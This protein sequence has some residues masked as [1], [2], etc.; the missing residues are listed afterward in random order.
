LIAAGRDRADIAADRAKW[1]E[2]MKD[3]DADKL[4]F[5]DES[6][7][8][9]KMTRLCGR[10]ARGAPCIGAVPDGHW[11]NNTF[12][13]GLRAARIDAPMLLTG[14]MNGAA[15]AAWVEQSL[16]PTLKPGDIVICDNLNVHKNASARRAIE[17]RGAALRFLPAY[18]PDLNPIEMLFA[19]LKN[20][21]RSAEARCFNPDN[22]ASG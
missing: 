13:A 22:S 20:H 14:A 11:R 6:G 4:V 2:E 1:C 21:V 10:A 19:K 18:S 15:F 16:A 7:F 9:T 5:I 12:I 8:D 3:L 17:A